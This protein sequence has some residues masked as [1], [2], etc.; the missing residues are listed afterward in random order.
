MAQNV[1]VN[2][3]NVGKLFGEQFEQMVQDNDS[4]TGAASEGWIEA[5]QEQGRTLRKKAP[6]A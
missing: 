5:L 6:G 4:N 2:G 3:I 1:I